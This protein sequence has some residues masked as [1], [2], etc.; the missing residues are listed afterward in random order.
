MG[1]R[2]EA[3]PVDWATRVMLDGGD[4]DRRF[5]IY[6]REN[7]K[8]VFTPAVRV[9]AAFQCEVFSATCACWVVAGVSHEKTGVA[10]SRGIFQQ[11]RSSA[12]DRRVSSMKGCAFPPFPFLSDRARQEARE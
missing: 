1:V 7:G 12:C 2:G 8:T 3:R 6:R 5:E 9:E 11:Q 4:I 10:V